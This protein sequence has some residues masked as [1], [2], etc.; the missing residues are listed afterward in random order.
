MN[1]LFLTAEQ[2]YSALALNKILLQTK[3][4]GNP[5]PEYIRT[6]MARK[7]NSTLS[8]C[9]DTTTIIWSKEGKCIYVG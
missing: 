5:G 2:C 4:G 7:V 9:H 1:I 3:G 8:H 6:E